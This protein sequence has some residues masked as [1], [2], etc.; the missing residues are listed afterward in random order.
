MEIAAFAEMTRGIIKEQGLDQFLPTL[1]L[2]ERQELAALEGVPEEK[3]AELRDI[4]LDW[5]K[6]KVDDREEFLLAFR[7]GPDSFR[8]LRRFRGRISEKVFAVVVG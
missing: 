7:E 1:C 5:A 2:P 3:Q 6:R 8:V 4:A